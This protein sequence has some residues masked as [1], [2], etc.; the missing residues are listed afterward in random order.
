MNPNQKRFSLPKNSLHVRPR[1]MQPTP[2][3]SPM[4]RLLLKLLLMPPL[5]KVLAKVL[6]LDSLLINLLVVKFYL[7]VA[8]EEDSAVDLVASTNS[9]GLRS[10]TTLNS[11]PLTPPMTPTSTLSPN[12]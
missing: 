10:V 5:P 4:P 11:P 12:T 7:M 8:S 2:P 6:S 3:L 1:L 9:D